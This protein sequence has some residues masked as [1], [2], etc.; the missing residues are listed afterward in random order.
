MKALVYNDEKNGFLL[1]KED[2]GCWELP[3]GGLDFGESPQEGLRREIWEE[4]R[5][6]TSYVEAQPSYF[7]TTVSHRGVF[8]ANV[9]YETRMVN[10]DLSPLLSAWR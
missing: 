8:I 9:M 5:L 1:V 4:M 10:L 6:E 3:G 2:N 7:F